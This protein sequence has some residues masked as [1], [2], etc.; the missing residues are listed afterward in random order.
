MRSYASCCSIICAGALLLVFGCGQPILTVDDAVAIGGEPVPLV[1]YAE[2][3]HF[4][5]LRSDLEEINVTFLLDG[6]VVG[7]GVAGDQSHTSV[8][9]KMPQPSPDH[10]Q[11]RA[12][13]FGK[14]FEDTGRIFHW[15]NDRNILVVD[16]DNTI[17]HTDYKNLVLAEVV[18][19]SP[20]IPGS[21][22]VLTRLAADYYILY[23]TARPRFLLKKTRS[24]LEQHD[25]PD[26][27]I[28]AAPRLRDAIRSMKYKYQALE[29]LQ[30]RCPRLLIG[31]GN[32]DGDVAAYGAN[33]MLPLMVNDG[34]NQEAR[35]HYPWVVWLHDWQDIGRFFDANSDLLSDAD[36]LRRFVRDGGM[37]KQPY[38]PWRPDG[39]LVE[40]D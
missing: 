33:R 39:L 30:K 8:V 9:V 2:R 11:A 15:R 6:Q 25:Y 23:L 19:V 20:P 1:A 5:G 13:M 38:V 35:V 36:A 22:E 34:D 26:G 29:A 16:I 4:L 17:S 21:R 10:F 14:T 7:Q 37:L 3:E 27:P 24:W 40:D 32:R 31:I 12:R 18:T 28:I